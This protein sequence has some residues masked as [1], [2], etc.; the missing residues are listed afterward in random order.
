MLETGIGFHLASRAVAGVAGIEQAVRDLVDIGTK[1]LKISEPP[2]QLGGHDENLFGVY[3][4]HEDSFLRRPK[5]TNAS[6]E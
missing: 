2:K 1:T 6:H 4:R 5:R 3:K